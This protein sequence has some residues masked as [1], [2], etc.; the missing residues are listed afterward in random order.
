MDKYKDWVISRGEFMRPRKGNYVMPI[1]DCI[2]LFKDYKTGEERVEEANR[3]YDIWE[4]NSPTK[5]KSS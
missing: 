4:T 3:L 1:D 2:K 5:I